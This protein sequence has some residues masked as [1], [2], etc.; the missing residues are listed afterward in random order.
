MGALVAVAA[1]GG[2]GFVEVLRRTWDDGDAVLP[3]DPRLPAPVLRR[4]V[5]VLQ[6]TTLETLGGTVDPALLDGIDGTRTLDGDALVVPTSGTTGEPKGVVLTHDAL[7]AHAAAV[8][9]HL[10]ATSSDRWLACL[11]LAHIGGL[12]VV[13][14][15]LVDGL[16]LEVHRG[17]DA[18]AVAGAREAGATLTSL[19]P[20]ALDRVG[21][22]GF[23]WVVLGGS[24]DTVARRPANVVRTW[25]LTETGG[26]VV[27]DGRPLAGV[28]VA[29]VDGELWVRSPTLA[30]GVRRADG[31]T[32]DLRRPLPHDRGSTGWLATG[33][34]GEVAADGTVTVRGRTDD[35]V[36]TGGENVWPDA[37]EAVLRRLPAVDQ[38]A[39]AG[40]P[41]PEW[42]QRVV[43]WVVPVDH[44]PPPT[45][46]GLRAAARAELPAYAAPRELRLVDHLPRTPLG[47]VR[48]ADLPDAAP[49]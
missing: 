15:A 47:K 44:R 33:D 11:P 28:E 35:M 19:V 12:G 43:A 17:F 20:T 41:D 10:G 2:P 13:V 32:R 14:R 40:R 46:D 30:R 45:L 16:G 25:G 42:G 5:T 29:E 9:D 4:L 24:A 31:S 34:A 22:D 36:V 7:A 27:Y 23:R 49:D 21:A 8:H 38:V 6:P 37:V 26:G 3:L 1:R 39:V 48:R 18:G